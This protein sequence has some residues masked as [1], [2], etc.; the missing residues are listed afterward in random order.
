MLSNPQTYFE[1]MKFHQKTHKEKVDLLLEV[2]NTIAFYKHEDDAV[3]MAQN[4]N[5]SRDE[6]IAWWTELKH[7]IDDV[8][9]PLWVGNANH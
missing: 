4:P 8:F 3:L 6:Y 2:K 5:I 7:L 1:Q 9:Y